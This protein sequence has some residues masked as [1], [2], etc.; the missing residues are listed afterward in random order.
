VDLY[1]AEARLVVEIDGPI[2][3]YSPGED[4]LRQEYLESLGF[5]ILRFSNNEIRNTLQD[6]LDRISVE[7]F[8]LKNVFTP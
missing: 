2:H 6:V 5:W 1:C 8:L 7:L 3:Q 4:K